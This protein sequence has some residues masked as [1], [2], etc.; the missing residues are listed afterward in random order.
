MH[1]QSINQ[2]RN[3]REQLAF[4]HIA[5]SFKMKFLSTVAILF[6]G[7]LVAKAAPGPAIDQTPNVSH[8][9]KASPRY[10]LFYDMIF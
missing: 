7:A 3:T 10:I 6:F 1:F 5:N 8:P 2:D 9:L 4:I